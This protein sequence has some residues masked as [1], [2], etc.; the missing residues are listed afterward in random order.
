M[1]GSHRPVYCYCCL[2][3]LPRHLESRHFCEAC[4]QHPWTQWCAPMVVRERM[5]WDPYLLKW[6]PRSVRAD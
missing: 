2:Y 3:L 6:V 5:K 4:E 1:M